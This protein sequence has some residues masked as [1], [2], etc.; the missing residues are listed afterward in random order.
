MT[1]LRITAGYT[2]SPYVQSATF[3]A[4]DNEV[5]LTLATLSKV[6]STASAAKK[7]SGNVIRRI[8]PVESVDGAFHRP[9]QGKLTVV[10]RSLIPLR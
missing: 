8:A 4:D 1:R 10:K 6:I 9:F 5:S 7:A 3:L 2:T